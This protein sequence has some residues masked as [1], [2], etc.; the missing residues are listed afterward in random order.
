MDFNFSL[1]KL[2]LEGTDD[3][4]VEIPDSDTPI[5]VGRL[6]AV[7]GT[8]TALFSSPLSSASQVTGGG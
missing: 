3:L 8:S 6:S 4:L 2:D 1:G 5:V 7:S